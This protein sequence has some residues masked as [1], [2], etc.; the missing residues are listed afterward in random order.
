[1]TKEHPN[2]GEY[3]NFFLLKIWIWMCMDTS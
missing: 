2:F 1:M 3:A